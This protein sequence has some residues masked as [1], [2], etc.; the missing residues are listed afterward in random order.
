MAQCRIGF[1]P[2]SGS[3]GRPFPRRPLLLAKLR[4]ALRS[5]APSQKTA[6]TRYSNS[7][8]SDP[9]KTAGSLF[10]FQRSR[11]GLSHL[12]WPINLPG[13]MGRKRSN[14][15]RF[16]LWSGDRLEAYP[17][18]RQGDFA[19]GRGHVPL[20]AFFLGISQSVD[21]CS[22]CGRPQHQHPNTPILL[23]D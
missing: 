21:H 16:V 3:T 6:Q 19:V 22:V 17:T 10:R 11:F 5:D 1:Q 23:V 13:I 8:L 9:N 4:I 2:V 20:N 7:K 18:L 14:S 12:F 15:R